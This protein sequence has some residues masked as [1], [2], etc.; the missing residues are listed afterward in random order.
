MVM[1]LL[2]AIAQLLAIHMAATIPI[3]VILDFSLA[4]LTPI[5]KSSFIYL[6]DCKCFISTYTYIYIEQVQNK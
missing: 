4:A 5:Y 2:A 1:P 6:H 3:V